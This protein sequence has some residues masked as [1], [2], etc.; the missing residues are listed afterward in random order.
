MPRISRSR[1]GGLFE[2]ASSD[3]KRTEIL[4]LVENAS[5][6]SCGRRCY[7]NAVP[8]RTLSPNDAA[9][10]IPSGLQHRFTVDDYHRMIDAGIVKEDDRVQLVDGVIIEMSP[11]SEPHARLIQ[12]LN[13][14]L[15]RGLSDDYVVRPQLPLTLGTKSEPEPDLAVVRAGDAASRD[16]HPK[17]AVLVI[18]VSSDSLRFDR[19]PKAAVYA[20]AAVAE[21]WIFDVAGRCVE[22]RWDPDSASARYRSTAT[23]DETA[24]LESKSIPGLAIALSSLFS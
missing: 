20:R 21:Y 24:T 13:R 11:Q 12:K 23:L 14:A 15:S 19:G 18:E 9:E 10:A 4:D 1:R 6:S 16:E 17:T 7:A 22:A 3:A 8:V 5:V 2:T